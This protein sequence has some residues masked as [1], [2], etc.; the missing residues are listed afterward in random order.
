M[1][2]HKL[3]RY[4]LVQ[5]LLVLGVVFSIL[6]T[7]LYFTGDLRAIV[8]EVRLAISA[9]LAD[10]SEKI[11]V[12]DLVAAGFDQPLL[13]THAG[14]GTSRLFVVEKAGVIKIIKDN[15]VLT[16][17]FLDLTAVVNSEASERGLLGLAFHPDYA[18]NGRFFVNYTNLAGNTIVAEYQVSPQNADLADSE[19]GIEIL[20]VT[21]PHANHN[22]GHLAFSPIDQYLYISLGD[23]GD[24]NDPE[25]DSQNANNML[26]TILR[27]DV[28]QEKPYAIPPDNPFTNGDGLAEIWAIGLRNPWRF[29]FDR[30]TGDLYIGD[31]GQNSWEEIDFM[32]AGQGG[33]NF[34]WNEREG[35]CPRGENELCSPAESQFTEPIAYYLTDS[36]NRSV[37]GGFVYRGSAYPT[38]QGQYI[39]G[40][41]LSG[42]IWSLD[43]TAEEMPSPVLQLDTDFLLS[44]FGEDEAGELYVVDFAGS[45][46]RLHF[47]E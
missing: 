35:P 42:R 18:V 6:V 25:G 40:D 19:S 37:V 34:G 41:F 30:Q 29:N 24:A 33:D 3:L 14:D 27:L 36:L 9:Q 12:D 22:G 31:V 2:I 28:D 44:S 32:A 15:A 13:V 8:R 5:I 21:Q 11:R 1:N 26:G 38:S 46:Y 39:F 45:V 20:R 10:T 23:G 43:T 4:K 17:P 7:I 47:N 16:T